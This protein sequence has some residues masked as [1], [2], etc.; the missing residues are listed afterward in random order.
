[1]AKSF[2][3]R[4][5]LDY[6]CQENL[7]EF[8]SFIIVISNFVSIQNN[9]GSLKFKIKK[10]RFIRFYEQLKYEDLTRDT[11]KAIKVLGWSIEKSETVPNNLKN[12]SRMVLKKL[13]DGV[14]SNGY[15]PKPFD[16]SSIT[17]TKEQDDLANTLAV[18]CHHIWSRKKKNELENVGA[19]LHHLLVPYELLTDRERASDL[20]FTFGLVKFLILNGYRLQNIESSLN[21]KRLALN[22]MHHDE[23]DKGYHDRTEIRFAFN[24]LEKL[25]EYVDKA[26]LN[27]QSIKESAK[28]SRKSSFKTSGGDVKFF[29]KVVLPLIEKYFQS[30]RSY[31]ILKSSSNKPGFGC[32][33]AKEK[34]MTCSLFCKLALLLRKKMSCFG[35]DTN[36]TVRCLQVL[37]R[38]VDVSS[39]IKNSQEIVRA[40]L[41][42]FFSYAADDL[43]SIIDD[44]TNNRLSNI[45][46][47]SQKTSASLDYIHMVLLPVLASMFDH[48][49]VNKYGTD[50]LISLPKLQKEIISR[51]FFF[52]KVSKEFKDI[53]IN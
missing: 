40:S 6:Y 8:T 37:I 51:L 11:L 49:G 44:L 38:A 12:A 2:V 46:G 9:Y 13:K 1:M 50:V 41:L 34:E 19:A 22:T 3:K 24:L 26:A 21:E 25:L 31:F 29:T 20:Q 53:L 35:S 17:L 33:T 5:K 14:V 7:F 47:T 27:M 23:S 36:I 18:N 42:P 45:K 15:M 28:F 4:R 39:V 48:L 10:R 52:K 16:L 43:S 30:H 32:A